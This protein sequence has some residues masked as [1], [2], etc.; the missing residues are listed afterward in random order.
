MH[1]HQIAIASAYRAAV[2]SCTLALMLNP[3]DEKLYLQ[4]G[5]SYFKLEHFDEAIADCTAA[6]KIDPSDAAALYTRGAAELKKGDIADG[7]ADV[8]SAKIIKP[9]IGNDL[10]IEIECTVGDQRRFP[11][12]YGCQPAP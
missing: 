12:I 3:S 7:N 2:S 8:R 6:L 10:G 5:L 1:N 4:R 9:D 11:H